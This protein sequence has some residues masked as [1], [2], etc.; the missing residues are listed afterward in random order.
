MRLT[1]W[2]IW[3]MILG[4]YGI[5]AQS[6]VSITPVTDSV[7]IGDPIAINLKIELSGGE[8][9]D[10]VDFSPWNNI[11]NLI[12]SSDTIN[13]QETLPLDILDGGRME[14]NESGE[15]LSASSWNFTTSGNKKIYQ[16]SL[17]VAIYDIGLFQIPTPT[18]IGTSNILPTEGPIITVTI[19]QS[20]QE[21]M[22]DSLEI[23]DIKP[24]LKESIKFEDFQWLVYGLVGLL[25]LIGAIV[26][27][28]TN[29]STDEAEELIPEVVFPAHIQALEALSSLKNKELWQQGKIKEYQSELTYIIRKYLEERY[30][31]PALENTT[32][33][34]V[35]SLPSEVNAEDLKEILQMADLIKFAKAEPDSSIHAAFM[36][37]AENLVHETKVIVD[38]GFID[39]LNA[40][41]EKRENQLTKRSGSLANPLHR[42]AATLIDTIAFGILNSSVL[43]ALI[44]LLGV[45]GISGLMSA[46]II[47]IMLLTIF[48]IYFIHA[49]VNWGKTLGK[50]LTGLR[51][52]NV[53]G[54]N[55]TTVQAINRYILKILWI[56]IAIAWLIN[57]GR[58]KKKLL[59]DT[60]TGTEVKGK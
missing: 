46:A 35:R 3:V 45:L 6:Y 16:D 55:I 52:G 9:L 40:L 39:E 56:V 22:G 8:T 10:A 54:D 36:T 5:A 23:A 47:G 12:Y 37:K 33:E 60:W 42:L 58:G 44:L 17:I 50:K 25:F 4:S 24:I 30:G 1:I 11:N 14:L 28:L 49:E 34:I 2:T 32:P 41:K 29:R 13:F 53:N 57:L 48:Y 21:T 15:T 27:L 59:H 7:T 18:L 38:Q 31:I 51:V 20:L 26:F 43:F 19:P